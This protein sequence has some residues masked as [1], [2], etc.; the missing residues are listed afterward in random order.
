MADLLGELGVAGVGGAAL[1]DLVG[2]LGVAADRDVE[3]VDATVVQGPTRQAVD[4]VVA[5]ED[6]DL[7]VGPMGHLRGQRAIAQTGVLECCRLA[8]D[9]R[10]PV[11]AGDEVV[12]LGHHDVDVFGHGC[13]GRSQV[14]APGEPELVGVVVDD[15][16]GPVLGGRQAGHAGDPP[17]L[18]VGVLGLVDQAQAAG[19]L[20][21][22]EDGHRAVHRAVV[23]GDH[24]V[25]AVVVVMG[26]VGL[27]HVLLVPDEEG[28]DQPHVSSSANRRRAASTAS[29]GVSAQ[30]ASEHWWVHSS[31]TDRSLP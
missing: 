30:A 20:L 21:G 8:D 13:Q 1:G 27:D 18:G 17:V 2:E 4:L 14:T 10:L 16:V 26:Q 12:A 6:G 3:D 24:E 23:G 31:Y 15:P 5:L 9:H 29:S 22:F 7:G 11:G 25:D 19:P 28:H